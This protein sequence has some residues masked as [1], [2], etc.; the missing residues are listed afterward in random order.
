MPRRKT[1]PEHTRTSRARKKPGGGK[2]R[3]TPAQL[4]RQEKV[5]ELSVCYGLTVRQIAAT[6]QI[7]LETV[8][9]DLRIEHKRRED[10][11]PD[12][13]ARALR[14]SVDFYTNV[15]REALTIAKKGR[16]P[17]DSGRLGDA[18][19]ARERIDKLYGN[20]SPTKIDHGFRELEDALN[21]E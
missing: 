17:G 8:I 6:L 7:S 13:R 16:M 4:E 14:E 18:I 19:K 11:D 3:R 1:D 2:T 12:R 10:E 15:A 20:D 5:Y 21:G 9:A